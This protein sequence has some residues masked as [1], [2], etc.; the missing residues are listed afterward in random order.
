[1]SLTPE[2]IAR[3]IVVAVFGRIEEISL[4]DL[5]GESAELAKAA[6]HLY[7]VVLKEFAPPEKTVNDYFPSAS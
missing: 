2:E 1:M 3:D 5:R 6:K 7:D 4:Q